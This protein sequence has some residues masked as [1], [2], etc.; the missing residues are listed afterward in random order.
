MEVLVLMFEFMVSCSVLGFKVLMSFPMCFVQLSVK[1]TVL[2][3]RHRAFMPRF[4]CSPQVLMLFSMFCIEIPML[5][6]VFY[7]EIPMFSPVLP[8]FVMSK[9]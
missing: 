7:I 3:L 2:P 4:M 5:F 9:A 1:P 8:L 6:T